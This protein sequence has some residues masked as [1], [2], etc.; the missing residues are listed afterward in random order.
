MRALATTMLATMLSFYAMS[1]ST[2]KKEDNA[3]PPLPPIAA[4]AELDTVSIPGAKL[5]WYNDGSAEYI[6]G[7]RSGNTSYGFSSSRD[8]QLCDFDIG[9]KDVKLL[10]PRVYQITPQKRYDIQYLP[11]KEGQYLNIKKFIH[12]FVRNDNM[13]DVRVPDNHEMDRDIRGIL[14]DIKPMENIK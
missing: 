10:A 1:C 14:I 6:H 12:L 2:Q 5:S 4:V 7:D 11:M 8:Y 13:E 9:G 3:I